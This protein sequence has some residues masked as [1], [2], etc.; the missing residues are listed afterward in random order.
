M[1]IIYNMLPMTP[2][3]TKLDTL[4]HRARALLTD[5]TAYGVYAGSAIVHGHGAVCMF[6]FMLSKPGAKPIQLTYAVQAPLTGEHPPP[7]PPPPLPPLRRILIAAITEGDMAPPDGTYRD[8]CTD[9]GYSPGS[10]V[11]TTAYSHCQ[12]VRAALEQFF[13]AD[14][15]PELVHLL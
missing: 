10:R 11:A 2:V 13:G 14:V 3:P 8:F 6:T 9:N 7:L 4:R 1:S 5:V 12:Q 15:Y